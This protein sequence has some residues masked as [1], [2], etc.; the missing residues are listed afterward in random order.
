[1]FHFIVKRYALST[2]LRKAQPSQA[3][4]LGATRVSLK[5][6]TRIRFMDS[7]DDIANYDRPRILRNAETYL[8]HSP[9][10]ITSV[11][12]ER[13]AGGLHDFYSEGDYWWPDPTGSDKPY[14]RR[15]GLSNPDNFSEHRHLLIRMSIEVGTLTAAW[16]MTGEERFARH[17]VRHLS[18]WFVEEPTRMNP[19]L[20][21]AQAI[22]GRVTGRGIGIVDTVHLT[23]VSLAAAELAAAGLS[24][25]AQLGSVQNWFRDYVGWLTSHPYGV[26]E[27]SQKNNHGSC[28]VMQVAA[29][30]KLTGN[31]AL[32]SYCRERF[33]QVLLPSQMALDGSFPLEL[34]RTKPYNYSIFNLELMAAI[35]ELGSERDSDLWT[36]TLPD[37]RGMRLALDFM[38]P[39]LRN[40]RDWPYP[41]DFM[42]HEEWPKRHNSILFG[43]LAFGVPNWLELWK[44]LE[45]ESTV[46]EVNRNLFIRQPVLW[47]RAKHSC[48][49]SF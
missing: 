32:L 19:S 38:I 10:T 36:H 28:W 17:A 20:A 43:G 9:L 13:S 18:A 12:C 7:P 35:C 39:Y 40:K 6:H 22:H 2:V 49:L 4:F 21:Y 47:L 33:T 1:V 8:A 31:E 46:F 34:E 29:F 24:S 14:V 5:L 44:S 23:E 48:R 25:S 11:R 41:E 45:A 30:S 15:D 26:N 37:G 16:C 3:A 42:Y 27:Q